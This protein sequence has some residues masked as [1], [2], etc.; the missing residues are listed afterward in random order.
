MSIEFLYNFDD[1]RQLIENILCKNGTPDDISSTVSESLLQAEGKGVLS[2]GIMRLPSYINLIKEGT[3]D[4]KARPEFHQEGAS[5]VTVDG[6]FG[7]GMLIG[8]ETSKMASKISSNTGICLAVGKN[9]N[10]LGMLEYFTELAAKE[11]HII[12][13]MTNAHPTV[14]YPGRKEPTIGTNPICISIPSEKGTFNFDMA[15]SKSSFGMIREAALEGKKIPEDIAI[16]REG[17]V[18]ND[19]ISALAG[20]LLPMGGIKGYALGMVVDM[21]A[22]ILSNS[23]VGKE[24][25]TWNDEGKRWNSGLVI[26][27]IDPSFFISREFFEM[28]VEQYLE[29]T[30]F[31]STPSCSR[32]QETKKPC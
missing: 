11:G 9:I 19:P 25:L 21:L 29:N 7:F 13:A 17:N 23:A 24:V 26:I 28:R 1:I 14:A 20:S 2:H 4:N 18:T 30:R 6:K 3:I 32:G 31:Y 8:L 22:G 15:I 12:I 27:S 5:A 16:D 10:H